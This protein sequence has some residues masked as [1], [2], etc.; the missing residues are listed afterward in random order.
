M[1]KMTVTIFDQKA[2]FFMQS[3]PAGRIILFR[4]TDISTTVKQLYQHIYLI[5]EARF[6]LQWWLKFMP[7]WLDRSLMLDSY[8]SLNTTMQLFTDAS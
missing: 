3:L 4:L 6:D 1:H 7:H 8:W 5:V 2:V